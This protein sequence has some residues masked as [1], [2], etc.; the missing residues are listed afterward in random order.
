VSETG[1]IT[2]S[3]KAVI[4]AAGIGA[5]AVSVIGLLSSYKT[6][7]TTAATSWGWQWPWALPVGIDLAIPSFTLIGLLLIQFD[8]PVGWVPFFPRALTAATVY[9]NWSSDRSVPGRVGHAALVML[10]VVFSEIAGRV[11]AH[12][13]ALRSE[14]RMERVRRIRWVLAPLSTASLWRRMQLWE[15]TSYREALS[16]ERNRK[17]VRAELRERFGWW[18]RFRTPRMDLV[19]LR[20]GELVPAN[21][22]PASAEVPANLPN[23]VPMVPEPSANQVP[24]QTTEPVPNQVPAGSAAVPNQTPEPAEPPAVNLDRNQPKRT[25]P[26]T[27]PVARP[28]NPG[29]P[30]A[31]EQVRQ[32]LDLIDEHGFD[33]VKLKFVM[34]ETGMSK[35]TAYNRLVEA[36]TA[37]S[38]AHEQ[39]NGD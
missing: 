12:R 13:A 7:S 10:W 18:W 34:D 9:L 20:L 17:L 16:K 2:A 33:T 37:W 6:L 24:N 23:Q 39:S 5:T 22:E 27:A 28:T 29:T 25:K 32:I 35:T 19:Q 8:I 1:E 21:L 31:T 11:Y 14:V 15:I 4:A 30:S 3:T 26:K 38:E 36:R